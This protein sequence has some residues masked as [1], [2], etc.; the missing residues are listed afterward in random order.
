[1]LQL[2]RVPSLTQSFLPAISGEKQAGGAQGR[3][4]DNAPQHFETRCCD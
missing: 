4:D 1:M 3:A 2:V